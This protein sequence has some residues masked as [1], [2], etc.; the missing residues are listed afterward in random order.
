MTQITREQI[1]LAKAAQ[2]HWA[3][4]HWDEDV[5]T[6]LSALIALGERIASGEAVVV[7]VEPD[8]DMLQTADD[9][10]KATYKDDNQRSEVSFMWMKVHRAVT[11][12]IITAAKEE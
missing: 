9:V 12:A 6:A 8:A 5:I 3:R 2:S 10:L 4:E 1:E 11:R 7:P